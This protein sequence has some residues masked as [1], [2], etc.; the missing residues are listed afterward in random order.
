MPY[1]KESSFAEQKISKKLFNPSEKIQEPTVEYIID[2]AC[3]S[4][5]DKKFIEDSQYQNA[6]AT[7]AI[8][9]F[10]D[11]TEIIEN[12]GFNDDNTLIIEKVNEN[13]Y[14]VTP[15]LLYFN[16]YELKLKKG[17]LVTNRKVY[18]P[19]YLKVYNVSDWNS[20]KLTSS[21]NVILLEDVTIEP[22]KVNESSGE[23][24]YNISSVYKDINNLLGNDKTISI[25]NGK[26]SYPIIRKIT[27]I[28]RDVNFKNIKIV[29]RGNTNYAGIIT[30]NSGTITNCS[31][32]NISIESGANQVGMV[33]MSNGYINNVHLKNISV[34]ASSYVGGLVGY[35]SGNDTNIHISN[36][37]AQNVFVSGKIYVGGIAG[38]ISYP[39]QNI[40]STNSIV[41]GNGDYVGGLV[42]KGNVSNSSISNSKIYAQGTYVGGAGGY[43][44]SKVENL[45]VENVQISD[46]YSTI[47]YSDFDD[48]NEIQKY[49]KETIQALY[50]KN[51]N[52]KSS[53]LVGGIYGYTYSVSKSQAKN[54][55]L[56]NK[57]DLEEYT[58][59]NA[60]NV[61]GIVG[62]YINNIKTNLVEDSIIYAK[63]NV[64]GI[65]GISSFTIS[66]NAVI[67]S[68][69]EAKGSNAGG[70][71]GKHGSV[72]YGEP[73]IST[74]QVMSSNIKSA[75]NSGGIVGYIEDISVYSQKISMVFN[76]A[77]DSNISGTNAGGIIGNLY[78][79]PDQATF[80]FFRGVFYGTVENSQPVSD[81]VHPLIG[82]IQNFATLGYY[83]D[84]QDIESFVEKIQYV[85]YVG[86][87]SESLQGYQINSLEKLKEVLPVTATLWRYPTGENGINYFPVLNALDISK[88]D[89]IEI[90]TGLLTRSKKRM[91]KN[92]SNVNISYNL[93]SSDVDKINIE[94]SEIDSNSQFYYEIGEYKSSLIPINKNTYTIYYD[95]KTPIKIHLE[96]GVNYKEK[97]Y[98]SSD[99]SRVI[100]LVGDKTYYIDSKTLYGE[101][102][103]IMGSFVNLYDNKA[104]TSN[105]K[106]YN[107]E[108]KEETDTTHSYELLDEAKPLYKFSYNNNSISTYYNYSLINDEKKDYQIII[109]NGKLNI[110]DNNLNNKKNS[111]IIDNYNDSEYQV[112]LQN[113]N[114]LYSLKNDI[115]KTD[116]FKNSDIEDM[117]TDIY[118]RNNLVVIKY[119]NGEIYTFDYRTGKKI[120]SNFSEDVSLLEYLYKKITNSG[121]QSEI[122]S[123][124]FDKYQEIEILKKKIEEISPEEASQKISNDNSSVTSGK[125]KY[126]SVYN[127]VT[128]DYDIYSV[129]DLL[130]SQEL[131][132]ENNK[133]YKDYELVRFYRNST[134]RNQK[135]SLNGIITFGLSIL[136]ILSTLY[137]LVNRKRKARGVA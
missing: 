23:T 125:K 32:E 5:I 121:S 126:I 25:T 101:A 47:A 10:E 19:F 116:D 100:T 124:S 91:V 40:S 96:Q 34:I 122:P 111:Y 76:M 118:G 93:Y 98:K 133:I 53:R 97:T 103:A 38:N 70:I 8:L 16:S 130:T 51:S 37:Y 89:Y 3:L 120:F 129:D 65:V 52:S 50:L 21:Q 72:T 109:K 86:G 60:E 29:K 114:S 73:V 15:N 17:E 99:L 54:I 48:D 108:T 79:V 24:E 107:I 68:Q 131:E 94:F 80:S 90:P 14:K 87:N 35:D 45:N 132:S 2:D 49:F 115:K 106:I 137:L 134:G 77:F 66:Q 46:D 6:C 39:I 13:K 42:G 83:I 113:T 28:M 9:T 102:K 74:N 71:I 135:F 11:G 81:D 110:I 18:L 63:N 57:N 58:A 56:A 117:Y 1:L 62:G 112:V 136:A 104:L 12:D 78:K 41:I 105:G 92:N 127:T 22:D 64:G 95:Y 75:E 31:F 128:S 33:G 85:E 67:G 61:G 43:S 82:K 119:S 59:L 69:I 44:S 55:I 84:S 27:K 7:S 4:K 36:I 88:E 20:L 30:N 26:V 123:A